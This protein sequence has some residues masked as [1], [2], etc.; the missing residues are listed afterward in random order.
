MMFE[1]IMKWLK[2]LLNSYFDEK[3]EGTINLN[4]STEME[5]KINE[6]VNL[7]E[8]KYKESIGLPAA[9]AAEI[10]RLVCME[11]EITV[12]GSPRAD[13]IQK[14]L[15]S[16]NLVDSVEKACALGGLVFKP[17]V[18][19]DKVI[20]E[21]NQADAFVPTEFD[22]SNNIIGVIFI[23]QITRANKIYTRLEKHNYDANKRT[24]SI[25]NIAF[26]S[27]ND[28][29]LGKQIE[30][31]SIP[32]W[33]DIIS[34]FILEDCDGPL[35][36]YLKMPF[37]NTVDRRSPIGVSV[38]SRSNA[39]RLIKDAE[40]QYSKYMWEFE[41]TELAVDVSETYLM[42]HQD[43][44]V[45]MPENKKRLFRGL[46]TRSGDFYEVFS[47]NIRDES[48]KR[49]FNTILQRIEFSVG[50]AY[51]TLS[52]PNLV[53]KTAEEIRSSKQRS[54][55]TVKLIQNAT[56]SAIKQLIYAV[57]RIASVYGIGGPQGEIQ[58]AFDWDDSIMNDPAARKQQ[59]WQYV[60]AGKF[61]A[62]R[63]YHEFEGYTE[64]EAKQIVAETSEGITDPYA[65]A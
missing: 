23:D 51:G 30:L 8:G 50:L 19:G 63:Y 3:S 62:W 40:S 37:T 24:H 33:E 60:V 1:K 61:P 21:T 52:D 41:G 54:Y 9:I 13:W 57:D 25:Q 6:W 17:Y 14:Q 32:E 12:T 45:S 10:A 26:E 31:T 53:E 47:P 5:A 2:K 65:N 34:D 27:S 48:I 11:C 42:P 46:D 4:I 15:F 35:F 36:A 22:S 20:V 59:F 39:D 49:G 55:S 64:E 38:F 44:S 43:G 7:Y 58:V 29:S 18:A 16:L 28:S 56:E